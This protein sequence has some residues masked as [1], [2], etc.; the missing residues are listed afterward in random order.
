MPWLI[1]ADGLGWVL[2]C[3]LLSSANRAAGA[4]PLLP[5]NGGEEATDPPV[6]AT[7]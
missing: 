2:Q 5:A 6:D 4:L 1:V 7:P 3:R